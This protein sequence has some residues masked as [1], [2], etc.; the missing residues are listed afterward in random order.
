MVLRCPVQLYVTALFDLIWVF[1]LNQVERALNLWAIEAYDWDASVPSKRTPT[2]KP[3][4]N[5]QTGRINTHA[6]AFNERNWGSETRSFL[7]SAR[8][9]RAHRVTEVKELAYKFSKPYLRGQSATETAIT[10]NYHGEVLVD[11]SSSGEEDA[12]LQDDDENCKFL[13]I[14]LFRI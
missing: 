10:N 12:M 6:H 3:V 9:M 2:F 14:C 5:K 1:N 4:L 11:L 8:V 7:E 13:L